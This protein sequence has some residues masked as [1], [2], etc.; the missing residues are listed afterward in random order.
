M[1]GSSLASGL[2]LVVRNPS[3]CAS[4][5]AI[6]PVPVPIST[7][8][9]LYIPWAWARRNDCFA[10]ELQATFHDVA[11]FPGEVSNGG[12]HGNIKA[13]ELLPAGDVLGG[14]SVCPKLQGRTVTVGAFLREDFLGWARR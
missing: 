11:R 3:S 5:R 12:S 7:T 13:P 1:I 4:A 6:A 14:Y 9:G 8:N 2:A 10:Q